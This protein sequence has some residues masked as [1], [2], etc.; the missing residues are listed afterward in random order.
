MITTALL[1][2]VIEGLIAGGVLGGICIAFIP[3][4]KVKPREEGTQ[5]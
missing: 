1:T 2:N 3:W 4:Q 5:R